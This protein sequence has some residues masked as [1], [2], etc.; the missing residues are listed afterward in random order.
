M[1]KQL[2]VKWKDVYEVVGIEPGIIVTQKGNIDLRNEDLQIET[3]EY[4]LKGGC[5]FIKLKKQ[6]VPDNSEI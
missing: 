5:P 1:A 4:L 6:A 3:I 2:K